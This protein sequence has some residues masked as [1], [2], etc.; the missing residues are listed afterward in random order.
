M[1]EKQKMLA[2]EWYHAGFEELRQDRNRCKSL[3]QQFNDPNEDR[4]AIARKLFGSY[5]MN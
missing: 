3:L 4:P 5:G 2:G 1:N